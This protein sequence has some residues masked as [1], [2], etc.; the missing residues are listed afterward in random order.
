VRRWA[1]GAVAVTLSVVAVMLNPV[2]SVISSIA[3]AA[4]VPRPS[5]RGEALSCTR[6]NGNEPLVRIAALSAV[7]AS[8][9]PVSCVVRCAVG[10]GAS[11]NRASLPGA[12]CCAPLPSV[13]RLPVAATASTAIGSEPPG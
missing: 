6:A 13:R 4:A 10:A 5:S 12:A 1:A 2:P 9:P 11:V 7:S 8:A 3:P